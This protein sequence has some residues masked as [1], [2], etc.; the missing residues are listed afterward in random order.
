LAP[1][2]ARRVGQD[3]F[4]T[5]TTTHPSPSHAFLEEERQLHLIDGQSW[6]NLI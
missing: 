2:L 3:P 5:T 1:I 6:S 4:T